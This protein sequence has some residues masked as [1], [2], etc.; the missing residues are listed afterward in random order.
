MPPVVYV[1][2]GLAVVAEDPSPK[3]QAYEAIVPSGSD[4]PVPLN[5]MATGAWPDVAEVVNDAVGATFGAATVIVLVI[6]PVA[7]WLS[8]TVRRAVKVPPVV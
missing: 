4:E 6:V 1:C 3:S 2:E 5:E 7:P 8:V